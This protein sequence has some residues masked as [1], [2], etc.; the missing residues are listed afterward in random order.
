MN[1]GVRLEILGK[2]AGLLFGCTR[3]LLEQLRVAGV[4]LGGGD[5]GGKIGGGFFRT[6]TLQRIFHADRHA[7]QAHLAGGDVVDAADDVDLLRGKRL[8]EDRLILVQTLDIELDVLLDGRSHEVARM[9][10]MR[11]DHG[12]LDGLDQLRQM[13]GQLGALRH[14]FDGGGDRAAIGVADAP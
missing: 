14:N 4:G 2:Y 12:G 5:G 8:G 7:D 9:P 1:S 3:H 11:G 10:C 6:P 13:A